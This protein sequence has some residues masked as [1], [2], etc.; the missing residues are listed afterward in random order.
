[1]PTNPPAITPPP[2]VPQR[3]VKATFGKLV[4][5]FNTWKAASVAQFSAV[6]LNTYNNAVEAFNSATSAGTSAGNAATSATNAAAFAQAA[7]EFASAASV[8]AGATL[9]V[10]GEVVQRDAAVISP[11]DRRTYRRK[12]MAGS[13]AVDPS[14][15]PT[16]YVLLSAD[17]SS[18]ML[19]A[20]TTV[21]A[22]TP[23]INFLNV[24]SNTYSKYTIEIEGLACAE[25][26][27]Q[28]KIRLAVA[29]VANTEAV[30]YAG[31]TAGTEVAGPGLSPTGSAF[32]L[33]VRG[34]RTSLLKSF[35]LSGAS[36]AG[37]VFNNTTDYCFNKTSLVTGFQLYLEMGANFTAGTV[38]VYGS[39]I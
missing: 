13:G 21:G 14:V 37:T 20:S 23:L 19:L 18:Y 32:T 38:R 33:T 25:A 16:N 2:E 7:N 27:R 8:T 11:A 22:A 4:D 31:Q 29:G 3:G 17:A 1:M 34:A 39:R 6:A 9:W 30:Y 35:G 15:D 28:L 10:S 36:I 12:T 26:A 24:F 5:A